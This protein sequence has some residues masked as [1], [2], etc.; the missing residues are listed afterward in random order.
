[1]ERHPRA[2]K[3]YAPWAS[4]PDLADTPP[5]YVWAFEVS[6]RIIPRMGFVTVT[7]IDVSIPAGH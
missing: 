7:H 4:N 2:Q 6:D 1:M 5:S 3:A